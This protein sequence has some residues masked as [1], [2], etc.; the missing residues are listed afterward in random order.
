ML[1]PGSSISFQLTGDEGAAL[2]TKHP[3]YKEDVQ[4][5]WTF[6]EYTKEHY[7]SWVTFARER[8]HPKDINPVLITGVDMTRD[9]A[10]MSYSNNDDD[11][12]A[13]FITSARDGA[14]PWGSWR[15]PGVVYSNCGPQLCRRPPSTTRT[16]DSASSGGGGHTETISD[17]YHQCVFIRYYTV[18]KRLGIPRVM[19]A[20]A[21]PHD[22]GPGSRDGKGLP[23]AARCDSD[24]SSDT[25]SS[26]FDADGD[27]GRSSD[28]SI[29][30]GSDIVIHNTTA[31]RSSPLLSII[32]CSN[33]FYIGRKGR[34]RYSCGLRFPGKLGT[35][36]LEMPRRL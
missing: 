16:M 25:A 36:V 19:K 26:P 15:T 27:D 28:T 33:W 18:R 5:G 4:L 8:G 11:L 2:L 3:T 10:M 20:A 17:E 6:E 14:S 35:A 31:V 22:L 34:F 32:A 29:D 12:T 9:F 7:D 23:I 1:E 30:S 24:S 21:G 13:E